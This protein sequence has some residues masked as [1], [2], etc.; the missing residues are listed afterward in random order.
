MISSLKPEHFRI[1]VVDDEEAA[2]LSLCE[3]LHLE[4]YQVEVAGDGDT[5]ISSITSHISHAIP[6]DLLLL[7]LKMPG[8][9]GLDILHFIAR[10][11]PEPSDPNRPEVILLT[12]H[13]SLESA[14]EALRFGAHDY[15]LKPS[16][17][18]QI[19]KS[20]NAAILHR[21]EPAQ[22]SK[23]FSQTE[24]TLQ[25]Q[26]SADSVMGLP[27]EHELESPSSTKGQPFGPQKIYGLAGDIQIDL[28]RRKITYQSPAGEES[29]LYLTPTEA[30]LMQVFLEHPKLVCSHSQLVFQVQG[31]DIK[32]WE[33]AE[34]LRPLISRLRRKL[35]QLPRGREWIVSI[36]GT[37]YV[38]DPPTA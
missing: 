34:V 24:F 27:S 20:V 10:T 5:A 22:N 14:I 2:R 11:I 4:G 30:K 6:Y 21:M 33:A 31:Y 3:I 15:L 26:I 25:P 12:A 8:T 36:R 18:E 29:G 1:L 35:S 38:F 13:G 16:S 37:G 28:I 23:T 19:V 7:D 9:D 17:P 32:D